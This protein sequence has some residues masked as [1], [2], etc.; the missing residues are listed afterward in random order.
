[1]GKQWKEPIPFEDRI[2]KILLTGLTIDGG[3]VSIVMLPEEIKEIQSRG[4][5]SLGCTHLETCHSGEMNYHCSIDDC[6]CGKETEW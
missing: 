5:D 2:D 6:G 1:M 4:R 3:Q